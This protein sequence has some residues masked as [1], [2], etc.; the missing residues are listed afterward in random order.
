MKL[1]GP[2]ACVG[3]ILAANAAL[4]IGVARNRAGGPRDVIE[5]SPRELDLEPRGPDNTGVTLRLRWLAG[6]TAWFDRAKLEDA[7]FDLQAPP[8]KAL[9]RQIFVVFELN[10]PGFQEWQRAHAGVDPRFVTRLVA[11][12]AGRDPQALR[13]RYP[14]SR[15]FAIVRGRARLLLEP[16][17]TPRGI[18]TGVEIDRIHVPLPHSRVLESLP[19]GVSPPRYTVSLAFGTRQEPWVVGVRLE[20]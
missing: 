10:G 7:G 19:A 6:D 4:L 13:R 17:S 15:R 12:D 14:D 20:P 9:P 11:I 18:I 16:P 1:S 3:V 5:L 2:A 8:G